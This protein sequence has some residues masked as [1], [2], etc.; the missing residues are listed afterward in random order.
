MSGS[1]IQIA[2]QALRDWLLLKLPAAVALINSQRIGKITATVAGPYVIPSGAIISFSNSR[3]GTWENISLTSGTRTAQ[4]VADQLNGTLTTTEAGVDST[5]RL[6]VACTDEAS[7]SSNTTSCVALKASATANAP[8]GWGA[9]GEYSLMAPIRAPTFNGVCDGNPLYPFDNSQGFW[10]VL[11]DRECTLWPG[12]DL[13]R[14]RDEFLCTFQVNIYRP[15]I[16]SQS[17]RSREAIASCARAVRDVLATVQGA[18]LGR[19]A[20]GDIITTDVVSEKISGT[21][22]TFSNSKSPN[23]A[24]DIAQLV[25]RVKVFKLPPTDGGN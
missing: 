6:Y 8:F 19:A 3:G 9:G 2:T 23:L 21:P 1:P 10:V 14:R 15:D 4:Q 11:D 5:G 20:D 18:Q 22:F 24:F 7:E 12:V 17:H 13:H 16:N 25:V